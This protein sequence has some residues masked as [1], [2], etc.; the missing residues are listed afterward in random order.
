[1]SVGP[2]TF[3][4]QAWAATHDAD[5]LSDYP[6]WKIRHLKNRHQISRLCCVRNLQKSVGTGGFVLGG[7]PLGGILCCSFYVSR[8]LQ[9]TGP[10]TIEKLLIQYKNLS[11]KACGLMTNLGGGIIHETQIRVC[12]KSRWNAVRKWDLFLKW[13]RPLGGSTSDEACRA[14]S[15]S[16]KCVQSNDLQE[17][18]R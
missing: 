3:K 11:P 13:S 4:Y 6:P 18:A 16:V 1:M 17:H 15:R 7:A 12:W 5:R 10:L 9:V 8:Y 2:D 14:T